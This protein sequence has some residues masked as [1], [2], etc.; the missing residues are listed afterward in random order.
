MVDTTDFGYSPQYS[1]SLSSLV[2]ELTNLLRNVFTRNKYIS[3]PPLQLAG[4]MFLNL[5]MEFSKTVFMTSG[6]CL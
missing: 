6:K 4:V 2:I 1:F 5:A 3:Q